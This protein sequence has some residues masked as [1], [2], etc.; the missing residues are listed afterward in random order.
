MDYRQCYHC[1]AFV[2]NLFEIQT[3][4][5]VCIE[6]KEEFVWLWIVEGVFV[7]VLCYLN[8]MFTLGLEVFF[9]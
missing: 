8:V 9:F 2:T 1:I 5:Y 7:S 4:I 6:S 3:W